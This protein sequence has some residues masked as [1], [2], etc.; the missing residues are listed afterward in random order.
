LLEDDTSE[1]APQYGIRAYVTGISD[2]HVTDQH[3]RLVDECAG[4]DH[5]NNS[6]DAVSGHS[7]LGLDGFVFVEKK[8]NFRGFI[9]E[10]QCLRS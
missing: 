2:D 3:S 10:V 9:S 7:V 8:I 5:W 1:I 6:F 4:M